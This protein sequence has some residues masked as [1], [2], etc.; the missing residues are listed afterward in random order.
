MA[1][2]NNQ[3]HIPLSAFLNPANASP[4]GNVRLNH[5]GTE[6][7]ATNSF[8]QK[9]VNWVTG[10]N[11]DTR[12]QFAQA[13]E[14][15]YGTEAAQFAL[16]PDWGF[17]SNDRGS[18]LSSTEVLGLNTLAASHRSNQDGFRF[19]D[20]LGLNP[21]GTRPGT[22]YEA[23]RAQTNPILGRD[24]EP[25]STVGRQGARSAPEQTP[26]SASA[27][28]APLPNYSDPNYSAANYSAPTGHE[29]DL[30]DAGQK[31]A[32]DSSRD[33]ISQLESSPNKIADFNDKKDQMHPVLK[34]ALGTS[35]ANDIIA[36][37][38]NAAATKNSTVFQASLANVQT[39][40]KEA[41][42]NFANYDQSQ[43]KNDEGTDLGW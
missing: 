35:G 40:L 13:L 36:Q 9:V 15:R 39:I 19:D 5:A 11:H 37:L 14:D 4:E 16:G 29:K 1:I 26:A 24:A 38:S 8:F 27:T 41:E 18:Q 31:T 12:Q 10:N 28:R 25:P 17:T 3:P 7:K 42:N 6:I 2:V 43:T 23:S 34:K 32:L 30:I 33:S 21:T 20:Q 22:Q